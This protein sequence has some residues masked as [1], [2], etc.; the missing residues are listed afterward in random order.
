MWFSCRVIEDRVR[1]R[2]DRA[3]HDGSQPIRSRAA[4][5]QNR[6]A[7]TSI[8]ITCAVFLLPTLY[9]VG[10]ANKRYDYYVL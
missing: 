2:D 8:P 1:V 7:N 9:G 5:K 6:G 10:S 3:A 4:E